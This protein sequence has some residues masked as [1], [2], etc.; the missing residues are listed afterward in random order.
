VDLDTTDIEVYGRLKEGVA[1]NYQ[2]QRVGRTHLATWAE[3]G[4][5]VAAQLGSGV[6]DPRPEA[7]DVLRRALAALP[8]GLGRPIARADSGY[9]DAKIAQAA[10]GLGCD[11]AFAVKRNPAVWA[12]G[13]AVPAT[14]WQP[15]RDMAG[16][17]V[18]E[19]GYQP[20]GW[21]EGTRCVV[22]RVP[23]VGAMPTKRS[24]RRRT[25]PP[26]QLLLGL[27]RLGPAYAY[28]FIP[29]NLP[30]D[31]VDVEAW[32]RRRA[33]IEE[34]IKDTKL[35]M[36]LRHLPSGRYRVNRVWMWAAVLALNLSA[37]AQTLGDVDTHPTDADQR[38][39][40]HGKRLR[41][42]LICV[43]ARIVTHARR[44]VIRPAPATLTGPFP[45]AFA[46]LQALPTWQ[47]R[48]G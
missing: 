4:V 19:C 10:V 14:G 30:G 22:R 7:A 41:R 5:A 1:Y 36:P 33:R 25:I 44:T 29:T 34:R 8:G 24:R 20:A 31:A 47:T 28:S 26:R 39:K 46:N 32:F 12:A 40:A 38:R 45:T 48:P 15:A 9:H 6:D 37:F 23:V 43:A 3:A 27:L 13:L 18:A 21:P 16:A 42:Q 35:G 11:F 2:G 17:E